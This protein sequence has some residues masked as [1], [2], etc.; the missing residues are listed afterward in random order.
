MR[1]QQP[2]PEDTGKN[3]TEAGALLQ[4][5]VNGDVIYG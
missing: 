2:T 5:A 1:K 4:I 3:S